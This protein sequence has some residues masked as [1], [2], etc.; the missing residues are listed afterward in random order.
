MLVKKNV[1]NEINKEGTFTQSFKDCYKI[2]R[3]VS[4]NLEALQIFLIKLT[5]KA[6]SEKA[7]LLYEFSFS[8]KLGDK[9]ND[10]QAWKN[11]SSLHPVSKEDHFQA[12]SKEDWWNILEAAN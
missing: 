12:N 8:L 11:Y 4:Q 3:K 6:S 5:A 9:P 7:S 2:K 1:L 10:I